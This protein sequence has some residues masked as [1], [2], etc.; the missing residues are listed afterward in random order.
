MLKK[1]LLG[2]GILLAALVL[3][4]VGYWLNYSQG[5]IAG[6]SIETPGATRCLLIASQGSDYKEALVRKLVARLQADS[7]SVRLV[8]VTQLPTVNEADYA[9]AILI[10]SIEYYAAQ[11]DVAAYIAAAQR[12]ERIVLHTTSGQGDMRP[13]QCR[14]DALTGASRS[15][16][17]DDQAA[18]ILAR[19]PRQT[20]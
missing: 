13:Q 11:K 20:P 18:A 9:A 8:D 5:V 2:A 12:P 3:F 6:S 10:C 17:L 16:L 15:E 1:L 19:L 7:A 14:I 4:C